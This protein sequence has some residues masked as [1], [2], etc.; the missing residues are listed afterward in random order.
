MNE[1]I[2][3]RQGFKE[4]DDVAIILMGLIQRTEYYRVLGGGMLVSESS[5]YITL[6]SEGIE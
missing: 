6:N 3:K 4:R 2:N 1:R 5:K